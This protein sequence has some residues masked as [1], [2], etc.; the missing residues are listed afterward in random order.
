MVFTPGW[1]PEKFIFKQFFTTSLSSPLTSLHIKI[2]YVSSAGSSEHL[3]GSCTTLPSATWLLPTH[4]C[5]GEKLTT[6]FTMTFWK[7]KHS[8]HFL[9]FLQPPH[10]QL[11]H[12]FPV[13]LPPNLNH[14]PQV[15]P[16]PQQA[17]LKHPSPPHR[18][19]SQ[20]LR[21]TS[22]AMIS[23]VIS[24]V[25]STASFSTY[26]VTKVVVASIPVP[27]A[28]KEFNNMPF[29]LSHCS[30]SSSVCIPNLARELMNHHDCQFASD[31]VHDLQFGCCIDYQGPCHH[32]ITPNWKS[33]LLHPDAVTEVLLKEVSRGDTA[34]PFSSL[35]LP[36]LHCSP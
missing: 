29:S 11:S 10:H 13:T 2:R 9:S 12:S 32:R 22:S 15:Q 19:P 14:L 27:S 34:G 24:V 26:A 8:L 28:L 23:T 30:L 17:H 5:R 25:T 33:T 36:T 3:H 4:H 31:L 1:R 21:P 35:P 7:R 20:P 6:N 18:P 16:P